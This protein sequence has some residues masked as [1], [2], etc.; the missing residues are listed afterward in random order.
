[1]VWRVQFGES[2]RHYA[3]TNMNEHSS[4]SHVLFKMMIKRGFTASGA[5]SSI[6]SNATEESNV[7]SNLATTLDNADWEKDPRVPVRVS[8]LNYVDLAGSERIKKTGATG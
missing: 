5:R 2:N 3:S 7:T 6:T 1:M 4:R 8:A